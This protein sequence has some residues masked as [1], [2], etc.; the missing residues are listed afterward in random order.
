MAEPK[1][2]REPKKEQLSFRITRTLGDKLRTYAAAE[3]RELVDFVRII[4]ED[5]VAAREPRGTATA[6]DAPASGADVRG[7]FDDE[8]EPKTEPSASTPAMPPTIKLPPRKP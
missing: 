6:Q 7:V 2:D 5:H 4:L 8:P 1:K 3:R